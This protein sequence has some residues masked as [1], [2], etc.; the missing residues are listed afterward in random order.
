MLDMTSAPRVYIAGT[1]TG[2]LNR[3]IFQAVFGPLT[4]QNLAVVLRNVGGVHR[5][6]WEL[7]L[8]DQVIWYWLRCLGMPMR[9]WGGVRSWKPDEVRNRGKAL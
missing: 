7:M 4:D 9:G 8:N 1:R 2:R 3:D 6:G 5:L